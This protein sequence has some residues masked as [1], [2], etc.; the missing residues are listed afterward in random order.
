MT[1]E[2]K[3]RLLKLW[4]TCFAGASPSR[5]AK[6]WRCFIGD[7]KAVRRGQSVYYARET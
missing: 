1:T 3:S 6:G 2:Q 7:L 5:P 4:S